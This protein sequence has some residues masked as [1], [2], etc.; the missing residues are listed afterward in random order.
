MDLPHAYAYTIAAIGSLAFLMFC[1]VLVVDFV[2]L[3]S[4]HLPGS[5]VA[6]DHNNLLFRV[7]RTVANTNEVIAIFVLAAIFCILSGASPGATAYAAWAF[8]ITRFLFALCYYFN[9][10]VFR[11]VMF[12]CSLLALAAL[13][14]IGSMAWF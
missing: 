8:V 3:R 6:A 2:G 9:F 10:Q 13:L 5:T 1:Q 11:S 12:G 4:K 14:I 7:S